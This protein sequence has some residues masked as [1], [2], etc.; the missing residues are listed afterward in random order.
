MII[1]K[2]TDI[3]II[4]PSL[5]HQPSSRFSS[6]KHN[7]RTIVCSFKIISQK[8]KSLGYFLNLSFMIGDN[9]TSN[10]RYR[11]RERVKNNVR[12]IEFTVHGLHTFV[13]ALCFCLFSET[14]F[15]DFEHFLLSSSSPGSKSESLPLP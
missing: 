4:F 8:L 12:N 3:R 9:R 15:A 1:H 5:R 2:A 7:I 11:K 13:E 14:P 10:E 6:L